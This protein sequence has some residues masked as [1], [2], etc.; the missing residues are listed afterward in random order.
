MASA[1]AQWRSKLGV[2]TPSGMAGRSGA[3]GSRRSCGCS[4]LMRDPDR[5]SFASAQ[6][7]PRRPGCR[8][9]GLGG[10]ARLT[11]TAANDVGL[12]LCV[13]H[14]EPLDVHDRIEGIHQLNKVHGARGTSWTVFLGRDAL[15]DE[16]GRMRGTDATN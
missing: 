7:P 1:Q 15:T 5:E 9:P 11:P 16:I 2:V 3:P 14:L 8:N 6:E 13:G 4:E 10:D 12:I